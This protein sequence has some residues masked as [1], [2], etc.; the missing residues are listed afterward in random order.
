MSRLARHCPAVLPHVARTVAR[1]RGVTHP[2]PFDGVTVSEDLIAEV[3]SMFPAR[4]PPGARSILFLYNSYYHFLHLAEGLRRRGWDAVLV[5][6][7]APE[8]G[9]N[10]FFHGEDVN[11]YHEDHGIFAARLRALFEIARRRYRM[12]HFAG[13]HV[14]SMFPQNYDRPLTIGGPAWDFLELKRHGLKIGYT[15]SGCH[16]GV[17][18]SV[19]KAHTGVCSK[20]VWELH[21]EVCADGINHA[22]GRKLVDT[23]D[24]IA[25]EVDWALEYR[26]ND[27]CFRE[28]LTTCLDSR[29]WH[30]D[31]EVPT[32]HRIE[33]A[34]GEK[35]IVHGFGN[36]AS[37]RRHG[38]DIKGS[39]AIVAAVERLRAE[40][41]RVRLL[42][43]SNVLSRDMRFLQVQADII[44]DQ[45]NYGRYGAQSR[46]GMM[47]GKPTLC[48]LEPRQPDAAGA[49]RSLA[50]CPLVEADEA[51]VYDV[52]KR[53]IDAPEERQRIG[54]ASRDYAL[55]WH[56]SDRCAARFEKVYD[57]VM[58]G[59]PAEAP[60]V[61]ESEF[62]Q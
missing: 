11:I 55:K 58:A 35:I 33:R 43:P 52:L 17:R 53:L 59:Q 54:A 46:E 10:R 44:V 36:A 9:G 24:L 7:F 31:L 39:A 62:E 30:P 25:V 45:L 21:P 56:D 22:W 15:V 40:G 37:R 5:N 26:G 57:R 19:F 34:A 4:P 49:L 51:S 61:F 3:E 8:H 13:M 18:Q 2:P 27:T 50:E 42:C 12:V 16:D 60:E 28:P 20:C 23:C 32:G 47:L 41:A 6:S 29:K 38:R 48:H 1:I 14:M